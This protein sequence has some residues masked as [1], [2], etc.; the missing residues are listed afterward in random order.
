[1]FL[2]IPQGARLAQGYI[3]A[4]R[5]DLPPDGLTYGVGNDS[6]LVIP[7]LFVLPSKKLP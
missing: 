7:K 6:R 5:L 4:A 1:M 2:N 3:R